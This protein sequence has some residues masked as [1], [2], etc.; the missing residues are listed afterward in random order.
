MCCYIAR[1]LLLQEASLQDD[2]AA[3]YF[4][5]HL[6]GVLRKADALNLRTTLD[7]HRRTLNLEVLDYCHSVAIHKLCA[8][9]VACHIICGCCLLACVELVATIG[10]YVK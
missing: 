8:I 1:S 9:A 7:D 6:L 3:I 4:A 10:A 2:A 5:V